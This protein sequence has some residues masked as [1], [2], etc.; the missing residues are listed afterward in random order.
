MSDNVKKHGLP[1]VGI[2]WLYRGEILARICSVDDGLDDE[3]FVNSPF[4]HVNTWPAIQQ[5]E[6]TRLPEL[7]ALEY[8]EVP[9]GRILYDKRRSA[10][11]CYLDR[12]TDS[13]ATRAVITA[14]FALAGQQMSIRYDDH[15]TT[16]Q[17]ELDRLFDE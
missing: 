3:Q 16:D 4:D 11:L 6:R 8:Q 15:Y 10:F 9:R 7:S 12:A 13:P 1:C 2:F 17:D 14:A 5:R